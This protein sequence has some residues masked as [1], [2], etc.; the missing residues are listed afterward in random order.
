M[1]L[2]AERDALTRELLAIDVYVVTAPVR[3]RWIAERLAM[4]RD[5]LT[6]G[7]RRCDLEGRSVFLDP[8]ER[9]PSESEADRELG[10]GGDV[11][12]EAERRRS[13]RVDCVPQLIR[14]V[15]GA[16]AKLDRRLQRV[17]RG[18]TLTELPVACRQPL[19]A[20]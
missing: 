12:R 3:R 8:E 14:A 10:A 5:P 2:E 4:Q 6:A 18:R 19:V 13:R 20:R 1:S 15:V 16:V 7:C 9:A 17:R 11:D